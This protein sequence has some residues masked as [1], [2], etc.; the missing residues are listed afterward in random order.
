MDEDP[1]TDERTR[2]L[3]E[4]TSREK[5]RVRL[6]SYLKARAKAATDQVVEHFFKWFAGLIVVVVLAWFGLASFFPGAYDRFF[7]VAP[8]TY[9]EKYSSA[10]KRPYFFM[11]LVQHAKTALDYDVKWDPHIPGNTVEVTY[12]M[13]L[14]KHPLSGNVLTK[15]Q[16]KYPHCV[17]MEW[18]QI[19]AADNE[20][21][22]R[23][24]VILSLGTLKGPTTKPDDPRKFYQCELP[25]PK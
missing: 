16:E 24:T 19:L 4:P 25:T 8:P 10:R 13:A 6:A 11:P 7:G 18:G 3:K 14:S 17:N 15:F 21:E 1:Q 9:D 22:Y 12:P 23:K 2:A 20:T 5:P